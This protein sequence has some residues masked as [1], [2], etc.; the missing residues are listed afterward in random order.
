[1]KRNGLVK[2]II[3]GVLALGIIAAMGIG[4]SST[5]SAAGFDHG[6]FFVSERRYPGR[7]YPYRYEHFRRDRFFFGG[8]RFYPRYR[9]WR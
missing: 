9:C 1:M 4:S 6:R 7:F 2:K 3:G 5:A 8:A